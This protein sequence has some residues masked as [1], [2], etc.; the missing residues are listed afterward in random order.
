MFCILYHISA[1]FYIMHDNFAMFPIFH[2]VEN[3]MIQ[4]LLSLSCLISLRGSFL[5]LILEFLFLLSNTSHLNVIS[6][7]RFC[8]SFAHRVIFYRL[9][10]PCYKISLIL[11][12]VCIALEYC[13]SHSQILDSFTVYSSIT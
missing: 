1:V 2:Y 10:C 4:P 11:Y 7:L 5:P 8:N 6:V 3:F 12:L 13:C 9:R